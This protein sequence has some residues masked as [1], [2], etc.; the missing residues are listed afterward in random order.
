M[1]DTPLSS[2]IDI[3]LIQSKQN[4]KKSLAR[5]TNELRRKKID[6]EFFLLKYFQL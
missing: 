2:V 1:S 6:L 4:K 5:T 3:S